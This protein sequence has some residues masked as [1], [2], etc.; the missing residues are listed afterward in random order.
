MADKWYDD[1]TAVA[2]FAQILEDAGILDPENPNS[3]KDFVRN[4]FKYTDLFESWKD[5]GFPAQGDDNWN[6]FTDLLVT[7]SAEAEEE[8]VE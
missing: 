7:E 1:H 2:A 5:L 4:P 8:E 3:Y 6:E